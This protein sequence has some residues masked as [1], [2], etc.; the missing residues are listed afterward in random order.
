M[1]RS[2]GVGQT[3]TSVRGLSFHTAHGP[4]QFNEL[5]PGQPPA[6]IGGKSHVIRP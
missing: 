2:V 4:V 6:I 1:K 5:G 3:V